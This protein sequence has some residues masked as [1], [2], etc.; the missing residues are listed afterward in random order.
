MGLRLDLPGSDAAMI[1]IAV[2]TMLTVHVNI[3]SFFFE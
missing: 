2:S 1:E 3:V